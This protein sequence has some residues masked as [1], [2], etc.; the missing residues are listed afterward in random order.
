M[1]TVEHL[2][3]EYPSKRALDEVHFEIGASSITA[4]VGPNGAG[5]STLLRCMAALYRP[6][7][8]RVRINGYDTC[9]EPRQVH[10]SLGYLSDFFGLYDEL[11][12]RR[13]LR[14]ACRTHGVDTGRVEHTARQLG[15]DSYLETPAGA[16]SR[17]LRQRLAIGLAIIHQPRVLLLDE[18]ASGL[19]PEAR[20]ALSQ[21]FLHLRDQGMTLVVSSHILAELEDYATEVLIIDQGRILDHHRIGAARQGSLLRIELSRPDPRLASLLQGWPELTPIQVDDQTARVG[22]TGDAQARAD[23]LAHL[24]G[25]GLAVS[26]FAA[27]GS[28]LQEVYVERMRRQRGEGTA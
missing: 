22:V 27:I 18:P 26:S 4:L 15:L 8:G 3:F 13:S 6:F 19:D 1:I 12:V 16:L 7:T 11:S 28:D 20:I 10:N 2:S 24:V 9:D 21:M 23:L 17:G 5:K 25:S 14:Y